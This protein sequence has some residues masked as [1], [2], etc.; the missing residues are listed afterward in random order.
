V[1][2]LLNCGFTGQGRELLAGRREPMLTATGPCTGTVVARTAATDSQPR[3]RGVST[4][5]ARTCPGAPRPD[6]LGGLRSQPEQVHRH[7]G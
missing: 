6:P 1:V 2:P 4:D 3:R 7:D 5:R